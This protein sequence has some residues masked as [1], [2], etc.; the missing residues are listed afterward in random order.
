LTGAQEA[1][2]HAEEIRIGKTFSRTEAIYMPI[3][4]GY[5]ERMTS[6]VR[7]RFGKA[8]AHPNYMGQNVDGECVRIA[9]Q[10]LLMQ[11]ETRRVMLVLSDGE[12]ACA[13]SHSDEIDADLHKAVSEAKRFGVEIVGIG[14][15]TN[16][17]KRYYP[18]SIVLNN[19]P[20]LPKTVMGELRRILLTA[21]R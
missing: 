7:A 11:N 16:S 1:L 21:D 13:T 15:Q 8:Y 9:M 18:R 5:E 6:D 12:P 3:Y 17:V 10:R 2:V 4:K 14:I 20:D 19:L